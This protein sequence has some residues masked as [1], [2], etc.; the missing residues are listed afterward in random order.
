LAG[1]TKS[2]KHLG[3]RRKGGWEF[4]LKRNLLKSFSKGKFLAWMNMYK[5]VQVGFEIIEVVCFC[6]NSS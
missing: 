2:A 1:F 6:F 4:F 5:T 3:K